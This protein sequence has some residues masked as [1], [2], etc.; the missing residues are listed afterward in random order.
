MLSF[1]TDELVWAIRRERED[2]A[3]NVR[4]HTQ[5]LHS[6]ERVTHEA[7]TRETEGTWIARALRFNAR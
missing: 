4:P 1:I 5:G 6:I 3:R 7:E 2:S